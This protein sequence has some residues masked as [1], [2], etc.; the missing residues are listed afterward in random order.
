[1]K[2]IF[3]KAVLDYWKRKSK[4]NIITTS[5]I[6]EEDEMPMNY[7][8]R[9]K[10]DMPDLEKVA[11]EQCRGSVLDIGA[12]TGNH[13]LEL[14]LKNIDVTA[15]DISKGA[16]IVAKERGVKKVVNSSI[17]DYSDNKF[18]TLLMLMNGIGLAGTVENLPSFLEK[19]K[20]LLNPGGQILLDSSD[21]S[22]M[23]EDEDGGM[24]MDLSREYHGELTF[25]MHYN[26]ESSEE[27][28]WLYIDFPKLQEI[29]DSCGLKT[30]F[31]FEGEHY[32]YL[33]R[34]ELK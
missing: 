30:E 31:V 22:Y 33:A 32:D 21:I 16:C 3:G 18:D 25:Q 13:S 1:M 29:A 15:L 28:D 7:L 24:W 19:L 23:F 2:D 5:N 8:F 11:L 27:F 12:G 17:E 9:R 20:S 10:I 14:Q 4:G 6:T 26:N 34:L